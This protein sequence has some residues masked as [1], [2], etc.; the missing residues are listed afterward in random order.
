MLKALGAS[1]V[2]LSTTALTKTAFAQAADAAEPFSFDS[3]TA[4]MRDMAQA[5]FKP[6]TFTLPDDFADLNYDTYRL[7]LY[8]PQR[9]KWIGADQSYQAQ[10]FHLGWLYAEPIRLFEVTEG[11]AKPIEF[12]AKDFEYLDKDLEARMNDQ[13]FPGIAGFRINHP[14][15]RAGVFDELISFVGASYFRALGRNNNYGLS[16]RGLAMDSWLAGPEEFPRFTEFYLERSPDST[17]VI[18]YAAL[19]SQRVT[20]A[21]R[22]EIDPAGEAHQET[23]IDVT[24]RLF[25]RGDVEELGVAPLTSMFLYAEANRA[26]FDDYRPQVHDSN[27]LLLETADGDVRWRALSNT[28]LLGNSYFGQTNPR[29]FGLYQRGRDFE[30]YQDAGAHYER[31]PSVRIEPIG[32]WGEGAVRLIEVPSDLEG[33]DN[34]VAFWVPS[35]P[36]RAGD[37]REFSYRM[38]WG[39]LDPGGDPAL[40]YVDETRAGVGGVSGV[41]YDGKT[42]KFVVDFKGGELANLA[43]DAQLEIVANATGGTIVTTTLTRVD[44]NGVWRMVLDV[45]PT[46]S[47]AVELDAHLVGADRKLTETWLYQW[48]ATA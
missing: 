4:R 44:A 2:L 28:P 45:E 47:G 40:A 8:R 20:G 34:I 38:I 13:P 29:A 7:I 1:A 35:E 5:E 9:G 27:G 32:E 14:L 19:D 42:R 33:N 30:T 48:R 46:G 16:A 17:T 39:D 31:R 12:S 18:L 10:A 3:F 26:D 25:F 11:V 23:I 6:V 21:F 22:L 41:E 24:A 43:P 36:V 37:E 15:N